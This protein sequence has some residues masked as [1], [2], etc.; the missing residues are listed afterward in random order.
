MATTYSLS[1]PESLTK[2]MGLL[3]TVP[4]KDTTSRETVGTGDGTETIFWLDKVGVLVDTYT[5][6]YGA[7]YTALTDVTDYALDLDTSK[8]TLTTTGVAKVGTSVIYAAYSFNIAE[9]LNSEIIKALNS[10]EDKVV[11][12]TEQYFANSADTDPAYRK[13]INESIKGHYNPYNKVYDLIFNPV[14]C[15][16]TTTNGA[17]TLTDTTLTLTDG[18]GLPNAG[19]IYVD[20]NKVT[21]TAR[22]THDLTVPATTPSI[23]DGATVRGE[24]IELSTK[25]EG[26]SPS[27]TVLTPNTEYEIDYMQGRVKILA[28]AYFGE[29]RSEDRLYPSNYLIRVSYMNAWRKY[30]EDATIPD[31]IEEVVNMIASKKFVQRI[32]RKNNVL[33][34]NDYDPVSLNSGDAEINR[35]LEYYRPLNVGSSMYNKQSLS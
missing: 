9:L 25:P 15:I 20:G 17:F 33:Q 28:K 35:V 32:I 30:G 23:D 10:A 31:E 8:I 27:Y 7:A 21:Y 13:I 14:I 11:Q 19:T 12:V 24:V 16:D 3:C 34:N 2:H 29:I 6:S 1:T 18:T 22:S 5:I 26:A 4:N